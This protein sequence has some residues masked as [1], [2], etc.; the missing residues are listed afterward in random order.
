VLFLHDGNCLAA[1]GSQQSSGSG[2]KVPPPRPPPP[3]TQL[4]A[5][6][7]FSIVTEPLPIILHGCFFNSS[8]HCFFLQLLFIENAV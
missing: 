7:W 4:P 1:A 3:G 8:E 2:D 6:G 5:Q